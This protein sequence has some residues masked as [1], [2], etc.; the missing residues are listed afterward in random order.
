[1]L[2]YNDYITRISYKNHIC[3]VYIVVIRM[4]NVPITFEN[5]NEHLIYD[6]EVDDMYYYVDGI[7]KENW[8]EPL[9]FKENKIVANTNDWLYLINADYK[10]MPMIN[11][12][13]LH[14]SMY[15]NILNE[16][17]PITNIDE[18]VINNIT[19]YSTG[20]THGYC[21]FFDLIM[22]Y[23]KVYAATEHKLL[24]YT[25]S[26]GGML[27][28]ID[29]LCNKGIL[30]KSKILYIDPYHVYKF[31]K[32][33]VP[34]VTMHIYSIICPHT[35]KC[36]EFIT[37]DII[38][39][40]IIEQYKQDRVNTHV[41]T[42]KT[43]ETDNVVAAGAFTK[44]SV[45]MFCNKNNILFLNAGIINEVVLIHKIHHCEVL[46][47][48]FGTSFMKNFVYIS[49]KCRKIVVYVLKGSHYEIQYENWH[50]TQS[51]TFRN[52]KFEYVFVTHDELSNLHVDKD[53]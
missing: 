38:D 22:N 26:S 15:S 35:K 7:I 47:A 53:N 21:G 29:H 8:I 12:A 34:K 36:N 9:G 6:T 40:S 19:A 51:N 25:E 39:N 3:S 52:A 18:P 28:I 11:L 32:A 49:D 41:S 50:K 37:R 17:T 24:V 48:S 43:A 20:T 42:I 5:M 23:I 30:N 45:D 13:N 46:Y 2:H 31:K 16:R 44:E 4:T 27:D 33:H 14:N 10:K 1:L